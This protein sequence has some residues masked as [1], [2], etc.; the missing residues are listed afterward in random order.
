MREA[1]KDTPISDFPKPSGLVEGVLI[2]TKTGL[3][4]TDDCNLPP[5]ETR[6][7][8]FIAGTELPK[9]HPAAPSLGGRVSP[10]S[11]RYVKQEALFP[12]YCFDGQAK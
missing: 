8:I 12:T 9:F 10:S 6:R 11:E 3:L 7:E 4:V 1:L 2:D 5:E